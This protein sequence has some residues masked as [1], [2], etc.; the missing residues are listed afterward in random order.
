MSAPYDDNRQP[1]AG[2]QF[3]SVLDDER[4]DAC[5]GCRHEGESLTLDQVK[6]AQLPATIQAVGKRGH[7]YTIDYLPGNRNAE[8]FRVTGSA[9]YH[10]TT[11]GPG[12]KGTPQD[13]WHHV[14]GCECGFCSVDGAR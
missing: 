11:F 12:G 10:N 8:R 2:C 13:G 3:C 9:P 1:D 7:N 5:E 14:D 6:A 4:P